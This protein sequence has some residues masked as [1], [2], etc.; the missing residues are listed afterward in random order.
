LNRDGCSSK[1]L[2]L[3]PRYTPIATLHILRDFTKSFVGKYS[4]GYISRRPRPASTITWA[5][6]GWFTH[7]TGVSQSNNGDSIAADDDKQHFIEQITTCNFGFARKGSLAGEPRFAGSELAKGSN[8]EKAL[9]N[10]GI[11]S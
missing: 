1:K 8:V 6:V 3:L 10:T 4:K 11:A 2:I 9:L 7:G 5:A